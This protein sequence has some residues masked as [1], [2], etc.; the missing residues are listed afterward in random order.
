MTFSS[1]TG[2]GR[3]ASA[4]AVFLVAAG[5]GASGQKLHTRKIVCV[6][7]APTCHFGKPVAGGYIFEPERL[8]GDPPARSRLARDAPSGV[9][10]L[11]VRIDEHGCVTDSC[12]RHGLRADVDAE[13][14][15]AVLQWRFEPA[16]LAR[17][18]DGRSVGTPVP[19]VI[20]VAVPI[21]R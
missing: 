4:I 14:R 17:P 7:V 8:E 9:V 16:A 10:I 6:C 19:I 3:A 1:S 21:G 5:S 12:V 2:F 15:A 11:E 20:T 18:A 13:A